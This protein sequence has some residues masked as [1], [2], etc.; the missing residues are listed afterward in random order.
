[1]ATYE[2]PKQTEGTLGGLIQLVSHH[3]NWGP[4]LSEEFERMALTAIRNALTTNAEAH[5]WM[6]REQEFELPLEADVICDETDEEDR[7]WRHDDDPFVLIREDV[8]VADG[9]VWPT[10]GEWRTRYIRIENEDGE[11]EVRRICDVWKTTVP[12]SPPTNTFKIAVDRALTITG[13][14]LSYRV[15]TRFYQLPQG[16]INL[17]QN[18]VSI[19]GQ[20]GNA[21]VRPASDMRYDMFDPEDRDASASRVNFR[22]FSSAQESLPTPPREPLVELDTGE[23]PVLWEGPDLPGTFQYAVSWGWGVWPNLTNTTNA[24]W[25]DRPFPRIISDLSRPSA[26]IE[27]DFEEAAIKIQLVDPEWFFGRGDHNLASPP[28]DEDRHGHTGLRAYVW[29]RQLTVGD[30]PDLLDDP[31][32]AT[33]APADGGWYLWRVVE[34]GDLES[35]ETLNT[36]Y[37]TGAIRVDRR[38]SPN[39]GPVK[40]ITPEFVPEEDGWLRFRARLSPDLLTSDSADMRLTPVGYNAIAY[41]AAAEIANSLGQLEVGGVLFRRYMELVNTL[42]PATPGASSNVIRKVGLRR[43]A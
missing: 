28:A 1:M 4:S 3:L 34:E 40:T 6:Y 32:F 37:D 36:I 43:R 23:E 30:T 9:D 35:Y 39:A 33:H 12:G 18:Q 7:V 16:T 19:K 21:E 41:Q 42:K 11:T 10:D 31:N 27:T 5:P 13:E 8:A 24:H 22:W 14:D 26:E 17:V 29:K 38:R 20:T 25:K 15:Y 2:L